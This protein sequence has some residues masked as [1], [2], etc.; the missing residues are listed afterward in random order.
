[1]MHDI[2]PVYFLDATRCNIPLG[3]GNDYEDDDDDDVKRA[4]NQ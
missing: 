1:M 3:D 4:K 2:Q